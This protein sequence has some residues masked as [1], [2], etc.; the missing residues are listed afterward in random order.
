M[1]ASLGVLGKNNLLKKDITHYSK[2]VDEITSL[3]E[4]RTNLSATGFSL[5]FI[6]GY[7]GVS[8]SID[9]TFAHPSEQMGDEVTVPPSS[10][11]E[12]VQPL[13][14]D[15]YGSQLPEMLSPHRKLATPHSPTRKFATQLSPNRKLAKN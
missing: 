4:E 5:E 9:D 7:K 1:D 6:K 15:K 11:I 10:V 8:Q 14:K 3:V 2:S 12:D 13:N